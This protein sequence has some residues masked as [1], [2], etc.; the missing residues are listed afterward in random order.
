MINR[1]KV[2][3]VVDVNRFKSMQLSRMQDIAG[4]RIIVKKIPD[5]YKVRDDINN[6]FPHKICYEKN[7]INEP[8]TDGYRCLHIIF[9][10]KGITKQKYNGLNVELQIRTELQHQWATAVE[11]IGLYKNT[12]YKSG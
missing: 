11:I 12:S 3:I 1:R 2:N 9:E 4:V 6:K 8:K 7:Y 10:M 5:I